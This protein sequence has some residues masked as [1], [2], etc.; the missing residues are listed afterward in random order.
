M[1]VVTA[2]DERLDAPNI[3]RGN[4]GPKGQNPTHESLLHVYIC[5]KDR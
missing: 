4:E 2:E 1:W 3:P 5:D